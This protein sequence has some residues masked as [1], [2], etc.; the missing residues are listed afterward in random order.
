MKEN[1][2]IICGEKRDGL[3][4]SDDFII[5]MIR[6]IKR[7]VTKNEK[8][9]RLVVCKDDFL[10]YKKARDSYQ[11][12]QMF[13]LVLGAVFAFTLIL[14]SGPNI[15]GAILYGAIIILFLYALAQ[16]SYM[17]ALTMPKN[18]KTKRK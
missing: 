10:K 9:Y 16:I 3:E 5:E 14:L 11:R 7:N 2:C 12:K 18:V 1:R 13:Y 8:G 4:V 17:P 15:L 6:W